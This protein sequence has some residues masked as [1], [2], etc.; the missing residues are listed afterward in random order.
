MVNLSDNH[1][2]ESYLIDRIIENCQTTFNYSNE[3]TIIASPSK[4]DPD[5]WYEW[6]RDA[7]IVINMLLDLVIC[8]KVDYNRIKNI[9]I[10]YVENNIIYQ[11]YALNNTYV[12]DGD[13]HFFVTLGEPKFNTDLS[14]FSK[15][16]G[17]PQNDGPALRAIAMMKYANY[18]HNCNNCAKTTFAKND[19]IKKYLYDSKW[20]ETDSLIKRDLEYIAKCWN[21]RCFDL[22]EEI[23]GHHFYTL[24]VQQK[25]L[26]LGHHFAIHMGDKH[27][28]DHYLNVSKKIGE[29]IKS[30]FYHNDTILS[31]IHINNS[32]N[33]QR[34][35]DSSIILA[36]IHSNKSYDAELANTIANMVVSFKQEYKINHKNKNM[37]IGRYNNDHY[38]GGNPW[39][40]TTGALAYFLLTVDMNNIDK[41]KLN[42]TFLNLFGS[43]NEELRKHGIDVIKSLMDIENH[44]QSHKSHLSYAE[45]FD[46]NNKK[47]L[48][49]NKLTWNYV[50]LLRS[51]ICIKN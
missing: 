39:V 17:R 31:S 38:Y 14:V 4:H 15:H 23:Y 18:L 26:E 45:Q 33:H 28:G 42:D 49:A 50:E 32:H 19:F 2:F 1:Y 12:Q 22:W 44:N 41:K 3:S 16:W 24:T 29:F 51:F 13:C 8:N 10:N 27:A 5:Y 43:S 40:L 30:H 20:P 34:Y 9:L 35:L 37:Y 47:Y 48:S 36:F 11:N 7:A 25:A 6:V 46:K 21:D